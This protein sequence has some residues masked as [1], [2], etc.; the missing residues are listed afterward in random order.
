MRC[1]ISRFFLN[2]LAH[3]TD[4]AYMTRYVDPL[5][6]VLAEVVC[7]IAGKMNL[8]QERDARIRILLDISPRLRYIEEEGENYDDGTRRGARCC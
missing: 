7:E 1:E 5:E 3:S 2:F 4:Y 6:R 8:P